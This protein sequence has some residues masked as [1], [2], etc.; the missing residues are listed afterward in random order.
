MSSDHAPYR[1]DAS[2][3]LSARD[4]ANFKQIAKGL[5]GL[6]TR[7][8]LLFD[9]MVSRG[10]ASVGA[11]VQVTAAAPAR[12]YGLQGLKGSLAVGADADIGIWNLDREVTLT[13]DGPH[14]NAGYHPFARRVVRGWHETVLRRGAVIVADVP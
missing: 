10:R 2:G 9:A 5:P 7:L 6:E 1:F 11:F 12:I 8:P 14:H 13:D 4:N 3:K